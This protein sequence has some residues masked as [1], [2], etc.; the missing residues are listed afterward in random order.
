MNE[1]ADPSMEGSIRH[2]AHARHIDGLDFT[3]L[4]PGDR[5][6]GG[7]MKPNPRLPWPVPVNPVSGHPLG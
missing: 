7:Q 1:S 3:G 5:D 2:M 6:A 4:V